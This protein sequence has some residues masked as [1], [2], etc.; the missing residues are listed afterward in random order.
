MTRED[1]ARLLEDAR[2]RAAARAAHPPFAPHAP[3]S[4]A[5]VWAPTCAALVLVLVAFLVLVAAW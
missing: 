3:E 4:T 5:R 2:A 1:R